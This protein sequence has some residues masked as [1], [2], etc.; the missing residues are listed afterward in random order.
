VV[1][2]LE[3]NVML[4]RLDLRGNSIGLVSWDVHVG[5]QGVLLGTSSPA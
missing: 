1:E 4:R 2:A 3:G 5:T